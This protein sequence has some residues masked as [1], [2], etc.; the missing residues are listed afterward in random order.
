M[1]DENEIPCVDVIV[2][3]AGFAGLSAAR[4]LSS[5]SIPC[6]VIEG[7][8]RLG[9]RTL[10]RTVSDGKD[11]SCTIDLGGQWIGPKQERVLS[12]IEQFQLDLIEQTWHQTH[13]S[14]L[15]QSIGLKGL[16]DDQLTKIALINEQWDQ[17]AHEVVGADLTLIS[18]ACEQWAEMSLAQFLQEHPL[19]VDDRRV[20]EELQLQI[21]TL[22][23]ERH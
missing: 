6:L 21:L 7:R 10:S 14:H 18:T 4:Y 12:L 15:G 23:G 11:K 3:G 16:S 1:E 8:C 17:M 9:G 22:T 5:R 13:P 19:L 2:V 20:E